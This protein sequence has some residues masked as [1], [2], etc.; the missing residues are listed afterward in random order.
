MKFV[1]L[2]IC[3]ST[4]NYNKGS[5]S[6]QQ[7]SSMSECELAKAHLENMSNRVE[8]VCMKVEQK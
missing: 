7:F 5:V 4:G 6:F 2:L 8:T 3:V 1:F